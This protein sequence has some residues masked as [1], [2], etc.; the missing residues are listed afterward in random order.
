MF[1]KIEQK[2][3]VVYQLNFKL[4]TA[5]FCSILMAISM[6]PHRVELTVSAAS[7]K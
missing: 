4:I 7:M 5:A 3:L 1:H 6:V 2:L